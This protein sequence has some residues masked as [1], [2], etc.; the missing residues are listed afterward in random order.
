LALVQTFSELPDMSDQ[1]ATHLE[2]A[3]SVPF[4]A[5]L[6]FDVLS[7]FL[8]FLIALPLCL[9]IAKAAGFPPISGVLTAV[10]GGLIPPLLSNSEMTIKGP[11]AGLII[12]VLFCVRDFGFSDGADPA[13]DVQAYRM[14]LAVGVAAAGVQILLGLCKAG[15]LGD[16]FPSSAVHG[17]LA[18]IG[19]IIMAKQ[20]PAALGVNAPAD[21][22]PIPLI[23]K[24]PEAVLHVHPI[25][26]VIGLASLAIMFLYPL[27]RLPLV[28]AVPVQLVVLAIAI[29]LGLWLQLG[30]PSDRWNLHPPAGSHSR[31]AHHDRPGAMEPTKAGQFLVDVPSPA[32]KVVDPAATAGL[33]IPDFSVLTNPALMYKAWKWVLLFAIIGS[34]E[35]LLSAKA[36]DILDPQ[37][38]KTNLNR[39][40]TAV[41]IAN[42]AAAMLGGMPMISEIVRSRANI[43]NGAKTRLANVFHGLFLLLSVALIPFLL[44]TIPLAALGAMLVYTGFRLAHP[45]E[46]W[47]VAK[48]GKE[49]LWVFVGTI[50]GVLTTDLLWGIVIG[51]GIELAVNVINGAHP[52]CLF[53]PRIDVRKLDEDSYLVCPRQCAVF[54]NWLGIRAKIDALGLKQN[55]N[56]VVD[57]S[58]TKLVDHSV[59]EK[60]HELKRDFA[61]RGLE[62]TIVGLDGHAALSTHPE[63]GRKCAAPALAA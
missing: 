23:L 45:K 37:K 11:A 60:L 47:H 42:L 41:G 40:L 1:K 39:D 29:P 7:G 31:A 17:L 12:I 38:R 19:V 30:K 58:A 63:S 57:L 25:V 21:L 26:G 35:S 9:A 44:K 53:V 24:L 61:Q 28:K 33:K 4:P 34:L 48:I 16:F 32:T 59:M 54:S 62:L 43:D 55:C 8:V 27:I 51:M 6:R 15:A 10:I 46:F 5:C 56:I 52:L 18:S 2:P 20:I 36:V 22:E 14:A 49:Q 3:P 13:A 50:I